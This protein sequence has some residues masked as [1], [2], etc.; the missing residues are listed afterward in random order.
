MTRF[1]RDLTSKFR[2]HVTRKDVW[3]WLLGDAIPSPSERQILI[4]QLNSQGWKVTPRD[5][6]R[7][8]AASNHPLFINLRLLRHSLDRSVLETMFFGDRHNKK[9]SE[10]ADQEV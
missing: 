9:G 8:T 4:T 2:R 5:F 6:V 3:A 7:S 1:M 10:N